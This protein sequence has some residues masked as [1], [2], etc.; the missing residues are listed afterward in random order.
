MDPNVV[1]DCQRVVPNRFA[2]A[3]AA[4]ARSR[5]LNRG[6]QP[7]L[8]LP[9]SD[10]RELA[11]QEIATGALSPEKLALFLPGPAA[12]VSLPVP[13]TMTTELRGDGPRSASAAPVSSPKETVH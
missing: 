2:L 8:D 7:R 10:M 3:L 4:A 9:A 12:T 13:P 6:A 1:F 5:A 11:L